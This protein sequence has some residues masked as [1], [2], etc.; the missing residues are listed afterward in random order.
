M[1]SRRNHKKSRLGCLQC[2][3][4]KVKC[5]EKVPRCSG[6]AK[7]NIACKYTSSSVN[8]LLLSRSLYSEDR[9]V[10]DTA[11]CSSS[12][13]WTT[14]RYL[15]SSSAH[16]TSLNDRFLLHAP[17]SIDPSTLSTSPSSLCALNMWG[18]SAERDNQFKSDL[19]IRELELMHHY[20]TQTYQS[21]S[22]TPE[23]QEIWKTIVPKE[24][25]T[26]RFLMHGLLALSALHLIRANIRKDKT[27]TTYVE[28]AT[29]HQSLG[30]NLFRQE[31]NHITPLNCHAAFAF[32]GI[33][34]ISAF[35]FSSCTGIKQGVG[36]V[37]EILQTFM[38][39]RGGVEILCIAWNWIENGQLGPIL[40]RKWN[41]TTLDD[42]VPQE[43]RNA[44]EHLDKLNNDN[45]DGI[46]KEACSSAIE[47]LRATFGKFYANSE[48][49]RI[50]MMWPIAI[51]AAYITLLHSRQPMALVIL[52]HYCIILQWLDGCWWM[53]GWSEQL[54]LAIYQSLDATWWSS[55]RCP[56]QIVGL[57]EKL[58]NQSQ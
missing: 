53:T 36:P 52:A 27:R 2:K 26:H 31:L 47:K 58:G 7:H 13:S 23:I 4:R 11:G 35:A 9:Q 56:M 51:P 10:F 8:K 34:S 44:L 12:S 38:L 21:F 49:M 17:L 50:A 24:A 19:F 48:K 33:L 57:V 1:P 32:S 29:I 16:E 6:C 20:S 42:S 41:G 18:Y 40:D 3:R 22:D 14:G 25:L 5:D 37:E 15:P 43:I 39:L 45:F 28:I 54:V 55:I 30:L 46:T